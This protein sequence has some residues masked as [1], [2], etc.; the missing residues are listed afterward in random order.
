MKRDR[1]LPESGAGVG[2]IRIRSFYTGSTL[3][4]VTSYENIQAWSGGTEPWKQLS[5]FVIG[6]VVLEGE[7]IIAENFENLWQG[8][9]VYEKVDA[10][11][12]WQ[13]KWPAEVHVE[14]EEKLPNEA[15]HKW[16]NAL[17]KTSHAVR[18][19]NGRAV[20]L[21]AWWPRRLW[22]GESK[23]SKDLDINLDPQ[24]NSTTHVKLG[25]IEAR[26][27]IYIPYLQELYRKHPAY[28]SLLNKVKSGVNIIILEPD[29]PPS[30]F[31][32]TGLEVDLNMLVHLQ[33]V[34]ELNQLLGLNTSS[35]K[36]V[37]YGHGYV[38]AL[39]LLEDVQGE[40]EKK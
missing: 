27:Q 8:L 35:K 12:T 21:Y 26:K 18:R 7:E 17:L 40:T 39:C 11:N 31:Y 36:Y 9:K 2:K 15:W 25:V 24:G 14:G 38:I 30:M 4:N 37:P 3:P 22:R 5:P 10:Q 13:W 16:H 28:Q 32:P 20:P 29:G 34:T 1:G 6:P 23:G 33:G 19:P